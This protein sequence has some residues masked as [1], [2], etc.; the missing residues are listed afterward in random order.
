M[1]CAPDFTLCQTQREMAA[2]GDATA[3]FE[4]AAPFLLLLLFQPVVHALLL[5]VAIGAAAL[6]TIALIGTFA[7]IL[8]AEL[9]KPPLHRLR[10]LLRW[11]KA[12]WV[13]AA[14]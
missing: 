3:S 10:W 7:A 1:T 9:A 14:C 2:P 5:V 4:A 11:V 8:V 13:R 6:V 12:Q